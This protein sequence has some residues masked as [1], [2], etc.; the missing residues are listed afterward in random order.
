MAKDSSSTMSLKLEPDLYL[1]LKRAA[2]EES[3]EQDEAIS[4]SELARQALREFLDKRERGRKGE[5][6]V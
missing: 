6:N 5:G 3:Y 4:A 2:R 1:E